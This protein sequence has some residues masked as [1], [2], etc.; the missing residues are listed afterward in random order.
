MK[1]YAMHGEVV[2][3]E[4]GCSAPTPLE[5]N[6]GFGVG[7]YHVDTAEGLKA[8]ADTLSEVMKS[9][10]EKMSEQKQQ[11]TATVCQKRS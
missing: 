4:G 3:V 8:L 1:L 9:A 6:K 2:R 11:A 7:C 10:A 5:Y